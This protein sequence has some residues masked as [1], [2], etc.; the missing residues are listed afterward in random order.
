MVLPAENPSRVMLFKLPLKSLKKLQNLTTIHS[1]DTQDLQNLCLQMPLERQPARRGTALH[2][3]GGIRLHTERRTRGHN[4]RLESH[5][6]TRRHT[7]PLRW[8]F[9]FHCGGSGTLLSVYGQNQGECSRPE[10][11]GLQCLHCPSI[12]SPFIIARHLDRDL[13]KC[14]FLRFE[15]KKFCTFCFSC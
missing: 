6:H 8:R 15:T 10:R 14:P 4:P 1:S 7:F 12:V 3:P 5:A 9:G 11:S 2:L 13:H